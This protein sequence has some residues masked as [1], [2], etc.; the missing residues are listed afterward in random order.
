MA[1]DGLALVASPA[2]GL[3]NIT[4]NDLA[5]LYGGYIVEWSELGAGEGE[6]LVVTRERGAL[7]RQV[8]TDAIMGETPISSAAVVQPHTQ[9]A[10]TFVA[11]TAG[12]LAYAPAAQVQSQGGKV[13]ALDDKL[14]TASQIERGGY[15]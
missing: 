5:R 3:A 11:E 8:F 15:P 9:A 14:P 6:P 10:L 12:A 2:L 13:V 4:A 1:V 7:L